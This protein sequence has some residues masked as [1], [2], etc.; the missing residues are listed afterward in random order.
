[1]VH[2]YHVILQ[3]VEL[4]KTHLLNVFNNVTI[5]ANNV[6][7]KVTVLNVK[8][9]N[10]LI[11]LIIVKPVIILYVVHVYLLILIVKYHA[12]LLVKLVVLMANV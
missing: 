1:M 6:M 2:V 3:F 5:L 11:H 7:F 10:L 4:V 12:T 9:I 8:I